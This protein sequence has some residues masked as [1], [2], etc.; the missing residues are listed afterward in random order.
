[1]VIKLLSY[2]HSDNCIFCQ[3]CVY[4]YVYAD[5]YGGGIWTGT[6][7]PKDSG[8]FTSSKIPVSC[9]LDSPIQCSVEDGSPLPSLGFI[10]SFGQDNRNDVFILSSTGVYRIIPPSRCN[11]TCSSENITRL[12]HP[13]SIP[14]PSPSLSNSTSRRL[15]ISFLV[16]LLLFFFS[17]FLFVFSCAL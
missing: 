8:N 16:Q 4:R 1:M 14:S 10:F 5:L 9:A 12:P 7:S 11:Y 17:L 2:H 6:E 15:G 13:T 3:N